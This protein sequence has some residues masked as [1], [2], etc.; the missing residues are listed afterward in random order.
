MPR[1]ILV[2]P[3]WKKK[4]RGGKDMTKKQYKRKAME[5]F[6]AFAKKNGGKFHYTDRINTPKWGSII[7]IG[8]HKGKAL[9]SYEQALDTINAI[10][11]G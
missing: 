5:I 1:N 11:N 7:T 8:P 10:I 4:N 6:R 9:R 2:L 3:Q